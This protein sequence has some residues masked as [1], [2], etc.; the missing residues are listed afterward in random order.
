MVK[1]NKQTNLKNK[2]NGTNKQAKPIWRTRLMVQINKQ[3][4]SEEQV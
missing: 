4:Q 1:T 3:N 2:F